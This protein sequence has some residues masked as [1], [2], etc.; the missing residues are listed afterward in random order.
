MPRKRTLSYQTNEGRKKKELLE[1]KLQD[2]QSIFPKI[3]EEINLVVSKKETAD[4]LNSV[5]H[6]LYEET[7]KLSKK[8]PNLISTNLI[9]EQV[10]QVI[11]EIKE[12]AESDAYIQRLNQFVPAGD[13]PEIQDVVIVLKQILQGL[14]RFKPFI[15]S[16]ETKANYK[17]SEAGLINDSLESLLE[18][19]IERY[20][21]E[22]PGGRH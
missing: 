22:T 10:N 9:V 19:D 18:E 7:E 5:A 21:N 1:G 8:N 13:N 16:L 15:N 11:K 6:G 17:K 3:R 20:A 14:Q 4:V 2:I 12:T